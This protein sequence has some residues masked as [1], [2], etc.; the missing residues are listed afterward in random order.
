MSKLC[1]KCGQKIGFRDKANHFRDIM[2]D[3][4]I[5]LHNDCYLNMSRDIRKKYC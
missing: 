1:W 2:N 4:K 3:D 5:I